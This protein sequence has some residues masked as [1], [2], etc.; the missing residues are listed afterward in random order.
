MLKLELQNIE[1]GFG[2]QQVLN[3]V[4]AEFREQ[5]MNSVI[6]VNGAGKSVLMKSIAGLLHAQGRVRLTDGDKEYGRDQ[7]AYVPQMA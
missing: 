2:R 4:N 3:G 5:T 6:G 1:I 7:I